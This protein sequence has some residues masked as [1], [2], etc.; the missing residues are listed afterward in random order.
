MKITVLNI[1][2]IIKDDKPVDY[3][4]LF[5][6]SSDT[7]AASSETKKEEAVDVEVEEKKEEEAK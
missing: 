2:F 1:I 5:N 6:L 3:V 4:D 7:G